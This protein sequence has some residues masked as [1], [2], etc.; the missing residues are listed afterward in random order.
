MSRLRYYWV[1]R[2]HSGATD[3]S[4]KSKNQAN[5]DATS[6]EDSLAIGSNVELQM[7]H[8]KYDFIYIIFQCNLTVIVIKWYFFM[9]NYVS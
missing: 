3:S 7:L 2:D 5:V 1:S 6:D 9:S 8:S 4:A